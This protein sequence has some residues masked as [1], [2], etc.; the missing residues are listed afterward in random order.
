MQ[1]LK[2]QWEGKI[3]IIFQS[4]EEV[5]K[6]AKLMLEQGVL[7]NPRVNA[8]L[9]L[10]L[11]P[12]FS[13]MSVGLKPGQINAYIKELFDEPNFISKVC[14]NSRECNNKHGYMSN[15]TVI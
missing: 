6:G 8:I 5:L 12:Q 1:E 15:S 10:H 9:G 11:D 14:L 2:S 13:L 4:G 3:R 7:D